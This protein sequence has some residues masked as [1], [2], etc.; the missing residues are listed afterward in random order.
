[1]VQVKEN[2]YG[3]RR[4]EV[5]S[6]LIHRGKLYYGLKEYTYEGERV[7]SKGIISMIKLGKSMDEKNSEVIFETEDELNLQEMG[8]IQAYKNKLFFKYRVIAKISL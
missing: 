1:M 7:Y 6:W 2:I 4:Q 3:R 8:N 5:G